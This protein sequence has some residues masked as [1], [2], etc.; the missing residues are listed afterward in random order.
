[1]RIRL[2]PLAAAIALTFSVGASAYTNER[3]LDARNFDTKVSP[4]VDFYRYAN[5]GWLASNAVPPE[6]STWGI[7]SELRERNLEI[8]KDILEDTAKTKAAPGSNAQKI[9]DFYASAMDVAAI[10]KAGAKPLA[11]MLAQVDALK[12]NADV[13]KLLREWHAKGLQGLF[14]FGAL[15]DLKNSSQVIA[16]AT[17]G[18]LGLPERE[19]YLKDDAESKAMRDKYVAHVERMLVLAGVPA[20]E[21]KQQ[22]RTVLTLETR[23]AKASMDQVAMRDPGNYYNIVTVAAADEQTP[24]FPWSAYLRTVGVEQESFSLAQPGFFAEVDKML[25]DVPTPQWQAYL[26]WNVVDFAAPYLSKAFVD[27]SFEFEGKTLTGAKEL[28][29]RWKRAMDATSANLGEALGQLYVE[30]TFPPQAK[31]KALELVNDLKVGL[32]GRLENL[33]WMGGDTKQK[34]M[35]KFATFTPKIGYPD[36]WRD[37]SG[38]EVAQRHYLENVLAGTAFEAKRQYAKIGKPVDRAEWQMT[39]QTVNAYYNPLQNEIV[40]PAAILQPPFFDPTIDDAVNYGAMGGV[41]GHEL[42]H[43]FDDQG[44]KFDAQ[45]NM[46]SWWTESDRKQ[47]EERTAKLVE[48]FGGYTAIDELKVNGKLTLGENIGDL[49]GLLVAYDAFQLTEQA[50]KREKI[51]GLTPDQRFFLSWAQAWR[52]NYRDEALKL[53]VNTDPHSPSNFRVIGPVSN[54]PAFAKAFGCRAGDPMVNKTRVD[55]W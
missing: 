28:R 50:K 44:S 47:F 32:K 40:F 51:V 12:T 31:A 46:T 13:A 6:Y 34:A 53:Q 3:G 23:L 1:M 4:C 21:A 49:G 26:R 54:M 11:P 36:T 29:P 22:A 14:N 7:G 16:Y 55:I 27:E 48:Q 18:G 9:G 17:Q 19:Y 41:I 10:E 5:G 25:G 15:A 39:P 52:R 33:E 45:G 42:M 24:N 43:G 8:L 38:L 20:A 30:R 35:E 2:A 37:Y